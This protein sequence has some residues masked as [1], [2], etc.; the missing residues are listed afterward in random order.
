MF[1]RKITKEINTKSADG[2][3]GFSDSWA[4]SSTF[5]A[6]VEVMSNKRMNEQERDFNGTVYQIRARSLSVGTLNEGD[7][8]LV[9]DGNNLEVFRFFNDT[10]DDRFITIIAG[11]G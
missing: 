3:G 8:R 1:K 10:E 4:T 6:D 2:A 7:Y 11:H 5:R 9:Y